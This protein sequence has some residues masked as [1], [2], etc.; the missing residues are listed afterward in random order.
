MALAHQLLQVG[1]QRHVR[2]LVEDPQ[3]RGDDRGLPGVQRPAQHE[4]QQTDEALLAAA[5]QFGVGLVAQVGREPVELAAQGPG[6][7]GVDGAHAAPEG[8]DLPVEGGDEVDVVRL[9]VGQ[10]QR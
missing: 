7:Q 3:G 8:D 9:E 6:V 1:D 10:N 2:A 5:A 4:V